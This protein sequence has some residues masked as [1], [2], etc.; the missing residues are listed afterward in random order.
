MKVRTYV[1]AVPF[2]LVLMASGNKEAKPTVGL[3]P[4]DLAPRIESLEKDSHVR[5]QNQEGRYTLLNFWAVYDAESRMRNVQLSN[6]AG[7]CDPQKLILCSVSLD[8]MKSVFEETI[9]T[10]RLEGTIQWQE[11]AGKASPVY[12]MYKLNKGFRNFLIDDKGVIVAAN[13]T[14]N[15]LEEL[16]KA[17]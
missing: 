15:Q 3:N 16:L 4:G 12:E 5:F 7:K 8:E 9:K 2:A 13:V 1:L 11:A 10:D 14:P 17:I 6:L